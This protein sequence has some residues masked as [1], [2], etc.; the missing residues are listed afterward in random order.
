MISNFLKFGIIILANGAARRH[1]VYED[2][3]SYKSSAQ[4]LNC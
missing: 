2:E 3:Q 1:N 4:E